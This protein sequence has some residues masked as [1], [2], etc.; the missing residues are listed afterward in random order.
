[1]VA[2]SSVVENREHRAKGRLV[3]RWLALLLK[4]GITAALISVL[5]LRIHP[6]SIVGTLKNFNASAIALVI[7]LVAMQAVI[8]GVRWHFILRLLDQPIGLAR[9]IQ[10]F[11]MG[12]FF[13]SVL[14]GGI[15]GDGVRIWM[16][17]QN[18]VSV[19]KAF[20][21]VLLD[22]VIGLIGL[23][24][25]LAADLPFATEV[26]PDRATR[27]L[28]AT[29]IAFGVIALLLIPAVVRLP[30]WLAKNRFVASLES[31]GAD[32]RNLSRSP[33]NLCGLLVVSILAMLLNA[34]AF[35]LLLRAASAD[36]HLADGIALAL[37]V[38][39]SLIL[40]ISIG[41][42]GIRELATV[43][44]FGGIG[45][46]SNAAVAVSLVIGII[47]I[48]VSLPGSLVWLKQTQR[49]QPIEKR[50]A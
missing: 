20:S 26:V 14:P 10:L 40:P 11:W 7:V 18:S 8:A 19:T 50:V 47:G 25:L 3:P 37:I 1:V 4:V 33:A 46:P 35:Y 24:L 17:H 16:L 13:A 28:A 48:V 2:P 43:V 41:G 22:R 39:L 32:L 5:L 49:A 31:I 42:W 23:M 38:I 9:T 44:L 21:S 27:L 15:A 34:L 30:I 12:M 29:V 45:V 6:S 36:V